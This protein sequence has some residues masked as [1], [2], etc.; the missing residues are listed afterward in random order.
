MY[1]VHEMVFEKSVAISLVSQYD[2]VLDCTD[3]VITR[4]LINDACVLLGKPLVSGSAL[5][6]EG[7]VIVFFIFFVLDS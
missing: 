5:K 6:F 2:V 3:N 4:Y 7:Q 1:D